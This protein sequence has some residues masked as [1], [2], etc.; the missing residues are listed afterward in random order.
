[1]HNSKE[2]L[3]SLKQLNCD[4]TKKEWY[5]KLP[6]IICTNKSTEGRIRFT[7]S[8]HASDDGNGRDANAPFAPFDPVNNNAQDFYVHWQPSKSA[9]LQG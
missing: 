2:R 7:T 1:M 5:P 6:D 9:P 4:E 8:S 3:D